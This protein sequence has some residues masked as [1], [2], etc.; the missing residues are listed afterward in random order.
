MTNKEAIKEIE[1][2]KTYVFYDI[3]GKEVVVKLSK[4]NLN[5]MLKDFK[6]GE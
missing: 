1:K 2:T 6:E 3:W 5:Q 4:R